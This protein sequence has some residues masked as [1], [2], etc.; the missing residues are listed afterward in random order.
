MQLL[1]FS[2]TTFKE[3]LFFCFIFLP[4]SRWEKPYKQKGKKKSFLRNIYDLLSPICSSKA[5]ERPL[6]I[7]FKLGLLFFLLHFFPLHF[8][9][10]SF[11]PQIDYTFFQPWCIYRVF[12][13]KKK[14]ERYSSFFR[15]FKFSF[16][17]GCL[18]IFYICFW[19]NIYKNTYTNDL[20]SRYIT[21][22][23]LQ[24]S[25]FYI[26]AI[27]TKHLFVQTTNIRIKKWRTSTKQAE[28]NHNLGQFWRFFIVGWTVARSDRVVVV[29]ES[30]TFTWRNFVTSW[31]LV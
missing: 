22:T 1:T 10:F 30:L 15:F 26:P 2:F 27:K 6:I 21:S 28:K 16:L 31:N 17:F 13:K 24:F 25:K 29:Q 11:L 20:H 7:F 8:S 23:L 4:K 19:Q 9:L 3:K 5:F 18:L 12:S 14:I